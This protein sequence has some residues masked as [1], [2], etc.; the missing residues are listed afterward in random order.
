M[1]LSIVV[2]AAAAKKNKF[3][4]QKSDLENLD[5]CIFENVV[6]DVRESVNSCEQLPCVCVLKGT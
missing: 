2:A 1:F 3:R 5:S 6:T 4:F